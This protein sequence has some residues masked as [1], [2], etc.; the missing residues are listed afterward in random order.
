MGRQLLIIIIGFFRWVVN[1]LKN[2][3]EEEIWGNNK[4]EA[5]I[6]MQNLLIG[7]IVVI[8]IILAIIIF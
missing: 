8:V 4:Y 6:S 1:G 7:L 5:D 3:L 2:S